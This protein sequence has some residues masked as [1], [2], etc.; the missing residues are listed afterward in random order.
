M[1]VA[2]IKWV[3]LAA[4][5]VVFIPWVLITLSRESNSAQVIEDSREF[6]EPR[7]QF[8]FAK[9]IQWDPQSFL[10]RGRNAGF[11]DWSE[12]GVV[13]T[14]KGQNHFV[15]NGPM[16]AGDLVV[17]KRK[18]TTVKSVQPNGDL[19]E[20]IFLWTWTDTTDAA[21]LFNQPLQMG[22][23]YQGVATLVDKGGG[24]WQVKSLS[25]PDFA[26]TVDILKAETIR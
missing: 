25:T 19:R 8:K 6:S 9:S 23:E 16:I 5:L 10:G 3:L 13:L 18:V 1:R 17:G 7:I 11:W 20:V 26:R 21:K 24:V 15:E 4:V 2:H 22:K 12:K 14:P